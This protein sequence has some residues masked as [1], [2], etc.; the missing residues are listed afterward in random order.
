MTAI[1]APRA[2]TVEVPVEPALGDTERLRER[3]DPHGIGTA[4]GQRGQARPDPLVA[5]GTGRSGHRVTQSGRAAVDTARHHD[6]G[7]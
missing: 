2:T 4:G 6:I 3:L 5:G 7:E 1:A